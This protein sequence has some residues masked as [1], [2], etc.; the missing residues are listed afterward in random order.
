VKEFWIYTGLR[1]LLFLASLALVVGVWFLLAD[2]VP[3]LWAVV[4]AFAMSGL[5][6]YFLLNGPRE[7]FA[8]RVENRAERM[9][10]RIEEM[11]AKE[12]VDGD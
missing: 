2:S 3:I 9:A 11:R 6:S 10:T 5:G 4:I 12:D 8:R 7:A 1:I